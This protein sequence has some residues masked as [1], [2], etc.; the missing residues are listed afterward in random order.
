VLRHSSCRRRTAKASPAA[1]SGISLTPVLM[2][3]RSRSRNKGV[4]TP[5]SRK[6][7]ASS[8]GVAL[9]QSPLI[10]LRI[11]ASPVRR[12]RVS[13][14][15]RTVRGGASTHQ[16][17][18]R[19]SCFCE[20]RSVPQ[21]AAARKQTRQTAGATDRASTV[22][23]EATGTE[24]TRCEPAPADRGRAC[25]PV[26]LQRRHTRHRYCASGHRHG[27]AQANGCRSP[28]AA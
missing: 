16:E 11:V 10:T 2:Q 21:S 27:N 26:S 6:A 17:H 9:P 20:K 23:V 28:S 13:S 12:G 15:R 18:P 4:A 7:F 25:R 24:V 1:L 22:A 5:G 19:N 8:F 3:Q 14:A